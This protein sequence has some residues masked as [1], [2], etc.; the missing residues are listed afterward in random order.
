MR[1]SQKHK[2]NT[3]VTRDVYGIIV[4]FTASR[5]HKI[6]TLAKYGQRN[7]LL[8]IQ[9]HMDSFIGIMILTKRE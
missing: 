9:N 4:L 6:A 5:S 2:S 3:R 8:N 1:S 7:Y